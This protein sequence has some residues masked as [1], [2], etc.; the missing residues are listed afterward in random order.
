MEA[1][2]IRRVRSAI[3]GRQAQTVAREERAGVS[4]QSGGA[5]QCRR[6]ERERGAAHGCP[7]R[8]AAIG[9][10]TIAHIAAMAIAQEA[11]SNRS[12]VRLSLAG[13]PHTRVMRSMADFMAPPAESAASRARSRPRGRAEARGQAR[14]R[15]PDRGS[16]LLQAR[17][18]TDR[19]ARSSEPPGKGDARPTGEAAGGRARYIGACECQPDGAENE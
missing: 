14:P 16:G 6:E 9:I 2:G 1:K 12:A 11:A 15:S 10:R 5:L 7:H 17:S 8:I 4:R 13:R 19:G 18:G 3:E